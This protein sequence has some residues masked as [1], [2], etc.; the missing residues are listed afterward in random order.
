MTAY[1]TGT[2][3]KQLSTVWL[4]LAS[5]LFLMAAEEARLSGQEENQANFQNKRPRTI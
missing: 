3:E 2:F 4:K 1:V 5:D